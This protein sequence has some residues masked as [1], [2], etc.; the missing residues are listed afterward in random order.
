MLPMVII[1]LRC[2]M[3]FRGSIDFPNG[4]VL[5]WKDVYKRQ[6][7]ECW[8]Y[9]KKGCWKEQAEEIIRAYHCFHHAIRHECADSGKDMNPVSY[10]HLHPLLAASKTRLQHFSVARVI[11][12][13]SVSP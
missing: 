11:S 13:R 5:L 9:G 1:R 10:T 6:I 3:A 4:L 12:E 2:R 7:Q 8:K